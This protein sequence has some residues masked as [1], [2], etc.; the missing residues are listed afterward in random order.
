VTEERLI[1]VDRLRRFAGTGLIAVAIE[2]IDLPDAEE[3]WG[4]TLALRLARQLEQELA[5]VTDDDQPWQRAQ[6]RV[7]DELGLLADALLPSRQQCIGLIAG[8]GHR[9]RG[10][11]RWAHHRPAGVGASADRG[12]AGSPA[13]AR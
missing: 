11:V 2:S 4:V 8:R 9:R 1:S 13:A 3:G 5:E 6:Q 7:N 12:G 10:H